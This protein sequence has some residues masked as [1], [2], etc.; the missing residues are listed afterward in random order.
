[1]RWSVLLPLPFAPTS[2]TDSPP[3]NSVSAVSLSTAVLELERLEGCGALARGLDARRAS[4]AEVDAL[5]AAVFDRGVVFLEDQTLTPEDQIAFARRIAPIV[6]NR[7]FPKTERYPE[8]AKVEKSEAQVSNIGGGWHTDHSYDAAPA[9]GSVLLAIE[10]PPSGGDTLFA[11]MYA[12]YDEL[13]APMRRYVDGLTAV[14][15]VT[16]SLELAMRALTLAERLGT[17]RFDPPFETRAILGRLSLDGRDPFRVALAQ[18]AN[19]ASRE[20][21]VAATVWLAS[22]SALARSWAGL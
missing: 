20:E 18:P 19:A 6:V 3:R 12:A 11:D 2:A 5:R 9:M 14:H 4:D 21:D 1:M 17:E 15:D 8:I 16:R 13:S 7:Y 22:S 10:T